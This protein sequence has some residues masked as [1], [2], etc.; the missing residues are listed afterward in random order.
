MVPPNL[1]IVIGF[2][3]YFVLPWDAVCTAPHSQYKLGAADGT[4]LGAADG[5]DDGSELGFDV[6]TSHVRPGESPSALSQVSM[7][8]IADGPYIVISS[9]VTSVIPRWITRYNVESTSTVTTR[10]LLRT[11]VAL[12]MI[13]S[14][15]FSSPISITS[16]L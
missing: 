3:M 13:F 10:T 15:T 9:D 11:S 6:G 8:V 4:T 2:S 7:C 5:L 1:R 16:S 14:T 12:M